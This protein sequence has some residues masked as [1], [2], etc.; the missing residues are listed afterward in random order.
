MSLLG[1]GILKGLGV[2]LKHF[3]VTYIEDFKYI[4]GKAGVAHAAEFLH[5]ALSLSHL[6]DCTAPQPCFKRK[7]L[8]GL[9]IPKRAIPSLW[10]GRGP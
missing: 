1:T 4:G 6:P 2:T 8:T 7:R 10:R 9:P 5:A 3:L